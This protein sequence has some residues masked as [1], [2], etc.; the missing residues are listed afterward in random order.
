MKDVQYK[1]FNEKF[2][3]KGDIYWKNLKLQSNQ[4]MSTESTIEKPI[5]FTLRDGELS[6]I[7]VSENE[8]GECFNKEK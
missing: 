5:K 8:A 4:T 6:E 1:S 7:I 2:Q 3:E